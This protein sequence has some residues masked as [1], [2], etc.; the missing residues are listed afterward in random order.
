MKAKMTVNK[1]FAISEIDPRVYG[2]LLGIWEGPY[3]PA[4]TNRAIRPR[5]QKAF[6]RT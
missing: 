1:D 4:Y 6:G 3:T 5:I 2:S